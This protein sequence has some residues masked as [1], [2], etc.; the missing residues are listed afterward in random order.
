MVLRE[1][2]NSDLF[3]G[4]GFGVAAGC[5]IGVLCA[6][7]AGRKTRLQVF[8]AIE[9]GVDY[10]K[11]TAEDTGKYIRDKT[12]RLHAAADELLDH[13][14]AVIKKS[15]AQLE[16]AVGALRRSQNA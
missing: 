11:S 1:H 3:L 12:S 7:Q 8:S 2:K 16:S 5:L 10:I 9:D 4:L 14:K 15:K 13:G 6:P